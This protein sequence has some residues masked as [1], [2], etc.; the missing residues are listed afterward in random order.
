MN[1]HPQSPPPIPPFLRRGYLQPEAQDECRAMAYDLYTAGNYPQA[2]MVSRDLLASD[3]T[4]WYHHCLLAASL[5][6]MGRFTESLAQL[7]VALRHL[8]GHRRLLALQMAIANSA[9]RAAH[10]YLTNASTRA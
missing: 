1:P 2:E 8:P 6:K 5:E 3:P 9:V 4:H 10:S 7:Q